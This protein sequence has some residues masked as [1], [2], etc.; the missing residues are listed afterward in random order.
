MIRIVFT[1]LGSIII[2]ATI[3][4]YINSQNNSKNIDQPVA[5]KSEVFH[6]NQDKSEDQVRR[7]LKPG[8][9]FHTYGDVGGNPN[10]IDCVQTVGKDGFTSCFGGYNKSRKLFLWVSCSEATKWGWLKP[11]ELVIIE[12]PTECPKAKE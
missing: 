2:T 10:V 3:M 9:C 11:E 4:L 8:R 5:P 12:C 6:P 7:L 1:S